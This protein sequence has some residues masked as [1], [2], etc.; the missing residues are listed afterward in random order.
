[1]RQ[2]H[3]SELV[4]RLARTAGLDC[5]DQLS[6][7]SLRHTAIISPDLHRVRQVGIDEIRSIFGG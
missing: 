2:S 3:L 5:A 4:R 6:P 1:M 7:H